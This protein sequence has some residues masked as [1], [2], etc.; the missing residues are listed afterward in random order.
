MLKSVL[1]AAMGWILL[2]SLA[3]SGCFE[4]ELTERNRIANLP[5]VD[6]IYHFAIS[7][8]G[9][10]I[11]EKDRKSLH[12]YNG[13]D[14]QVT[15]SADQ[16]GYFFLVSLNSPSGL[17]LAGQFFGEEGGQ[18]KYT[19]FDFEGR[20]VLGPLSTASIVE[21]SPNG[22]YFYSIYDV[23]NNYNEPALY[24]S[25]GE[26][27][28]HLKSTTGDW[29]LQFTDDSRLLFRDG[30]KIRILSFPQLHIITTYEVGDVTFAELP[31][32]ALSRDGSTYAFQSHDAIVVV[33]LINGYIS[34]IK[35]TE[36][37]E[38]PM[39]PHFLISDSGKSLVLF[40]FLEGSNVVDIFERKD[41]DYVIVQDSF[42]VPFDKVL[43]FVP[44][45]SFIRNGKCISNFCHNVNST[46]QYESFVFEIASN[47]SL[48]DCGEIVD[49]LVLQT[50]S[51]E[52]FELIRLSN[53]EA[54]ISDLK[55]R[56][57]HQ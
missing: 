7:E 24:D 28:S 20:P 48:S 19:A 33:D 16:G 32:S 42:R 56:R 43:S 9:L 31:R 41:S 15:V 49:G 1:Y 25:T 13:N 51:T 30:G 57:E 2:S 38:V 45:L 17:V 11:I 55:I 22:R 8:N 54:T 10:A 23:G 14:S 18:K 34:E 40:I 35:K 46:F 3:V 12:I 4:I 27:I 37:N 29:D 52:V 26:L 50:D 44:D 6:W 36:I 21:I 5:E 53:Q 39:N 47:V